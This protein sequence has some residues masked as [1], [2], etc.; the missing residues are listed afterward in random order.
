MANP[1]QRF[2]RYL[3]AHQAGG[4]PVELT[5]SSSELAFLAFDTVIKRLVELHILNKG[6]PMDA[7]PRRS[8]IDRIAQAKELR[9]LSFMRVLDHGEEAGAVYYSTNLNDGEALDCYV[10]RRGA[11]PA[12]TAFCLVQQYLDDLIAGRKCERLLC[13][14]KVGAPLVAT[15]EDAF[16]QLRIIDYGLSEHE[17][18]NDELRTRRVVAECGRLLFTLLTGQSYSGQSPDRFPALTSLPTNL[19]TLL[20]TA[21]VDPDNVTPVLEKMRDDVREAHGTLVSNLQARNS[22]KGL[23]LTDALQPLSHVQELLLEKMPVAE[24][25]KGRY[26]VAQGEDVKRFPFSIPAVHS[27]SRQAVS[28]HLLPPS[29]IVAKSQYDAVPLQMWRFNPQTHPHILRSLSLW[30]TPDWT[31]LTEER[32]PGFTLSRLLAERSNLNP[33]EVALLLKQVSAGIDQAKECGVSRIDIHPSNLLLKVGREG[34]NQNREVERLMQKRI[35]AWPPFV[36]KVRAH[37]TMRSLFEP[38]L[39]EP[40]LAGKELLPQMADK[41]FCNRSFVAL[42][43]YLLTGERQVGASPDFGETVP[44]ALAAY[45]KQMVTAA[46]VPGGAPTPDVF[47][48]AF[49]SHMMPPNPEGR[50]L[51]AIRAAGAAS[52][53]DLESV[54]SVSDFDEDWSS[55][56]DGPDYL[57]KT[58]TGPLGLGVKA[59]PTE[60]KVDRGGFG[61]LLFAGASAVLLGIVYLTVF[62][63]SGNQK[64]IAQDS[65]G[66]AP[67]KAIETAAAPDGNR[68]VLPVPADSTAGAPPSKPADPTPAKTKGPEEIKKAILPPRWEVE[69]LRR[70]QGSVY[71]V[72]QE[73]SSGGGAPK[74][75]EVTE[76]PR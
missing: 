23:L 67:S 48:Q 35:D 7:A 41:D 20:R 8:A 38:L 49:E 56:E 36:L 4:A 29:R 39:V 1:Q 13:Q 21:L 37:A 53:D 9:G 5:R 60:E 31:F 11:V 43:V 3:I 55:S 18:L 44:E 30:E 50:G 15:H 16:L 24:L 72:S 22:R 33:T 70:S 73:L 68:Q 10:A 59:L 45:L 74:I 28:V 61:M 47:L 26:D 58:K 6:Q 62:S 57:V 25:L 54:G 42:A 71:P 75:A 69:Q 19:R 46:R 32:E 51:A 76:P 34:A 17:P 2:G 52:A 66:A 65:Q 14:M 27:T 40:S 12:V 63:G 64:Q